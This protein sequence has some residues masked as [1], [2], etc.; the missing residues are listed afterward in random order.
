M[1][2]K[3]AVWLA[4]VLVLASPRAARAERLVAV[5][6]V[7][8]AADR[9]VAG[10]VEGQTSDLDVEL[11]V[12]ARPATPVIDPAAA[13]RGRGAR[14]VVWFERDAS[15]WLVHVAEP[16]EDRELVRRVAARG[17]LAGSA[18]AEGVALV[19]RGALRALAEGGS[20]GVA[21]SADAVRRGF[22]ALGWRAV[23]AGGPPVH[24]GVGARAGVRAGRWHG[25]VSTAL[26]PAVSLEEP[27][28]TIEV[29]RW[30]LAAGVGLELGDEPGSA[31][32][33]WRLGLA[34]DA[35]AA[36]FERVTTRAEG[37]LSPTPPESIWSPT[38]SGRGQVA[39]RLGD[40]VWLELTVGA[41]VLLRAPE[42]GV[43][44]GSVFSVHTRLRPI[45]P[46]GALGL[47]I[48]LG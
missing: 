8:D 30:S 37:L 33:R 9:E 47:L 15:S 42:F 32:R 18:N 19:V 34:L 25:V 3:A 10:R 12:A 36:R 17:E 20:I 39:R 43:A 21:A 1:I 6:L 46:L 7:A 11:V 4:T 45:E 16:A 38:V 44:S 26:F 27:G 2:G 13:A 35:G 14:V 5:V 22:A 41:E 31:S 23:A 48:D 24:H 29:E 28:A 40:R